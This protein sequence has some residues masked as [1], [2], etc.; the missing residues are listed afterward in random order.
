MD[1]WR[2]M[3]HLWGIGVLGLDEL[4]AKTLELGDAGPE[5]SVGFNFLL[6]AVEP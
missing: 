1:G 6:Y 5:T 3:S 4:G 2:V